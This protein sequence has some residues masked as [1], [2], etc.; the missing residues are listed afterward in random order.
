MTMDE[1][2]EKIAQE[3]NELHDELKEK[4]SDIG[5]SGRYTVEYRKGLVEIFKKLFGRKLTEDGECP[6]CK[7]WEGWVKY[8]CPTCKGTGSITITLE[9][10]IEEWEK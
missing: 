3:F 8:N 6:E 1:V 4:L 9:K 10:L 7:R 2:I 5:C